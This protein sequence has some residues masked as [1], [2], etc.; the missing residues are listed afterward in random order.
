MRRAEL[1]R[2]RASCGAR[3]EGDVRAAGAACGN[4]GKPCVRSAHFDVRS[5]L[6]G[7]VPAVRRRA[8]VGAVPRA[9]LVAGSALG[10]AAHRHSGGLLH[11]EWLSCMFMCT[12]ACARLCCLAYGCCAAA[13][14]PALGTQR[15]VSLCF[16][17]PGLQSAWASGLWGV[18]SSVWQAALQLASAY[19]CRRAAPALRPWAPCCVCWPRT[20]WRAWRRSGRRTGAGGAGG[21]RGQPCTTKGLVASGL[22]R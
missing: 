13:A 20:C 22:Y 10:A 19:P 17:A 6:P 15:T 4:A 5:V 7:G 8:A 9:G 3:D 11:C 18:A 12:C 16:P 14:A 21:P 2:A 1:G